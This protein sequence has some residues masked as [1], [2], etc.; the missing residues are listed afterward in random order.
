MVNGTIMN[1]Y[2][3]LLLCKRLHQYANP[4]VT[5]I[6]AEIVNRNETAPVTNEQNASNHDLKT[7]INIMKQN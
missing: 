1:T 6:L 3:M 2:K 4:T 5:I 7:N